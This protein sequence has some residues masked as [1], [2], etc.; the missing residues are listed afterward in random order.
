M[1]VKYLPATRNLLSDAL[2]R[3]VELA[4]PLDKTSRPADLDVGDYLD[5]ALMV[6]DVVRDKLDEDELVGRFLGDM[7]GNQQYLD[8]A[9]ALQ[10]GRARHDVKYKL[11]KD[12]FA[13][14]TL[15]FYD[16][17]SVET[18][19]DGRLLVVYDSSR[20]YIPPNYVASLAKKVHDACHQGLHKTMESTRALYFW[21]G[22]RKSFEK[23]VS[24]C[25]QCILFSPSQAAGQPN[26]PRL[27]VVS[28]PMEQVF[29]D[30]FE[31]QGS[32]FMLM[33][34]ALSG[35]MWLKKLNTTTA[36]KVVAK[37]HS[38]FCT[39]GFALK[40]NFDGGP[41]FNSAQV[42]NYLK[43][44]GVTHGL[45]SVDNPNSN[46]LAEI[47]VKLAKGVLKKVR[48]GHGKSKRRAQ[49]A[50]YHLNCQARVKGY[51]PAD[52]FF[53]RR[54]RSSLLPALHTSLTGEEL[55]RQAGN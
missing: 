39:V 26:E 17:L 11:N 46:S 42:K 44:H 1:Q 47:S 32:K 45:S 14:C 15:D 20:I 9:R 38:W 19:H 40:A 28:Q 10:E 29:C 27:A 55:Q 35:Y 33:A 50:I 13:R 22:M 37:L 31:L 16:K 8:V 12:N 18:L 48:A 6:S 23:L 21:P 36:E 41:P 49:T 43:D 3:T 5:V 24:R 34:D 52:L 2:S 51:S 30:L 7:A 25:D 4:T 54:L 53:N